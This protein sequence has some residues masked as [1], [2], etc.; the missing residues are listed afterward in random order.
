MIFLKK[1]LI[2]AMNENTTGV[3]CPVC[4]VS[5]E[6]SQLVEC[7][8]YKTGA[9]KDCLPMCESCFIDSYLPMCER[10]KKL[11]SCPYCGDTIYASDL[12]NRGVLKEVARHYSVLL[13]NRPPQFLDEEMNRGNVIEKLRKARRRFM[14]DTFPKELISLAKKL[15]PK[16]YNEVMV[17]KDIFIPKS[18]SV[19][20]PCPKISCRGKIVED[21]ESNA[22]CNICGGK[23]CMV[24]KEIKKDDEHKCDPDTIASLR[25]LS[26]LTSCPRCS[27]LIEKASGCN[28][29]TC[30]SCGH[31]FKFTS[32]DTSS[33]G[34]DS[35]VFEGR[36]EY[37]ISS[38]YGEFLEQKGFTKRIKD[39]EELFGKVT[40][41]ETLTKQL[42][43][44][45]V[46]FKDTK[47]TSM[48][49]LDGIYRA[50]ARVAHDKVCNKEVSRISTEIERLCREGD[51]RMLDLFYLARS[52]RSLVGLYSKK[53][54][55]STS[56]KADDS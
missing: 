46:H 55:T 27:V 28:N 36:K 49:A 4:F 34:G 24:C 8:L 11:A 26:K 45:I 50:Y 30:T 44:R 12:L 2:T 33:A 15:Y 37:T 35:R 42:A 53:P 3:I 39:I 1:L 32:G 10:E 16:L 54:F 14:R 21:A 51:L 22:E 56:L 20:A 48:K 23:F 5:T 18:A 31:K 19:L 38:E 47:S 7:P 40:Y 25:E 43:G 17:S 41:E 13:V 52:A 9:R 6:D 29:M